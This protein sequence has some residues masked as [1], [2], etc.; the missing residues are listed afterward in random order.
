MLPIIRRVLQEF[1]IIAAKKA[2]QA[3]VREPEKLVQTNN[4][5]DFNELKSFVPTMTVGEMKSYGGLG[6]GALMKNGKIAGEVTVIDGVAYCTRK[7][8]S[9]YPLGNE[10]TVC[11]AQISHLP[12]ERSYSIEAQNREELERKL[13]ELLPESQRGA[14][15]VRLS[16]TFDQIKLRSVDGGTANYHSLDE[17]IRDQAEFQF[18]GSKNFTLAGVYNATDH[19]CEHD[20]PCGLHLHAVDE[21]HQSGGHVLD[22]QGFHGTAEILPIQQW[23]ID[24][25]G[26]DRDV[27]QFRT[28]V[29]KAEEANVAAEGGWV[30]YT[31]NRRWAAYANAHRA[32]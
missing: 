18:D 5:G 26:N 12:P 2:Q 17:V 7:D 14:F 4:F 27:R 8:G 28:A 31:E 24:L 6:L 23:L 29:P 20:S 21:A 10:E 13:T 32:A 16:G 19:I 22:F 15:T 30:E 9:T 3:M 25:P 1:G 11:F